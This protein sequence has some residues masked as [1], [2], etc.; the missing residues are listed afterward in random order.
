MTMVPATMVD[1]LGQTGLAQGFGVS[2]AVAGPIT[3]LIL[4]ATG[5]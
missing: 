2:Y 4:P 5:R 1:I 3:M